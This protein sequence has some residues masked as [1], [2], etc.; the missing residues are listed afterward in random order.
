[1]GDKIRIAAIGLGWVTTHRHIPA[2]ARN[3]SF[4]LVGVVDRHKG[5]ADAFAA[6]HPLPFATCT[7]NLEDLS[8]LDQ[9]DAITIGTPPHTHAKLVQEALSKGKH[10]LTE[11]PF[12]MNEA[13]GQK[14]AQAAQDNKRILA[15]V[16]NF[17]FARAVTAFEKDFKKGIYGKITRIAATQLGNPSRRLPSWYESLPLGLFFD[18]SPHFYYLL[19][20][21]A[22]SLKLLDSS[23]VMGEM[24][25]PELVHLLYHNEDKVPVTIDCQFN[26]TLSEWFIRITGEKETA[27]LD[28]FRDIYIRLPN[29]EEHAAK[30][31][32]RTSLNVIT[33]HTLSHVPRGI[34]LLRGT[35]DYGNDE[36]FARFAKAIQNNARPEGINFDDAC[37]VLHYQCEAFSSL[38]RHKFS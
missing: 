1:M 29:D 14:M 6:S 24:E 21:L 34:S 12:A 28:I 9:V 16:H 17:Q 37:R 30:N 2:I 5:R 4:E 8:W 38:Q 36:V 22:G 7:D 26:S 33:Q 32:L 23:C 15:V 3:K 11:K 31:I 18:E 10:V 19:D 27:F 13:E 35:L 20:R 25:T